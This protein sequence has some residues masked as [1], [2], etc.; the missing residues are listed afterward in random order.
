[1]RSHG[2]GTGRRG[3]VVRLTSQGPASRVR[4]LAEPRCRNWLQKQVAVSNPRRVAPGDASRVFA[5]EGDCHLRERRGRG[6][7]LG[8]FIDGGINWRAVGGKVHC[9]DLQPLR[10]QVWLRSKAER[11]MC[12]TSGA[13]HGI[14]LQRRCDTRVLMCISSRSDRIDQLPCT[15]A[16]SWLN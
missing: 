10:S 8:Q 13:G 9:G 3:V 4:A 7:A 12:G 1:M 15:C 11:T 14:K 2:G 5:G 6:L 16:S